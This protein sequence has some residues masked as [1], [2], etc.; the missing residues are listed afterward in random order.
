LSSEETFVPPQEYRDFIKKINGLHKR[1]ARVLPLESRMRVLDVAT[2][3]AYFSMELAALNPTLKIIGIDNSEESVK[4]AERNVREK[5]LDSDISILKMDPKRLEFQ[6]SS[7]GLATNFLGLEEIHMYQGTQGL[8]ETFHE[9]AR[10][11]KPRGY[12][13]FTI[14]PPEEAETPAQRL[15]CEVISYLSGITCLPTI[16]YQEF[17]RGAGLTL[18]KRETFY[19]GKKLTI[20]QAKEKIAS[21][22][23]QF[24]KIF[25]V[26]TK[27][28]DEVWRRF[29]PEIEVN[30][31][32]HCSRVVLMIARKNN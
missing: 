27:S 8:R 9:V 14:M 7:F 22:C 4:M 26:K 28:F 16:R 21:A 3:S 12:F 1:V 13:C 29:S 18:L 17:L 19:T 32:G 31:L 10:V 5:W 15:E 24:T 2:G 20:E 25:G 11:L 6:A 23:E 30:G